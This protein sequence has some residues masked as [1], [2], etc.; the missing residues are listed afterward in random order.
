MLPSP[1]SSKPHP[2]LLRKSFADITRGWS[3]IKWGKTPVFVKHLT[4]FD[5]IE[6][7]DYYDAQLA[8]ARKNGI[9]SEV[10]KAKWL[11]KKGMW[12]KK[13]DLDLVMQRDF[14]KNL[15]L[16]KTKAFL[17]SQIAA[18]EK[19]LVVERKALRDM[20]EKRSASFG[21]ID[22][23]YAA[24]KMQFYYVGLSFYRDRGLTN[25]M[26]S[27][28]DV[29]QMDEDESYDL[30]SL[31]ID[32]ITRFDLDIIKRIS[33]ASFFVNSLYLCGEDPSRFFGKPVVDLTFYQTNLLSYGLY[34]KNVMS[35]EKVPEAIRDDPDKIEEFMNRTKASK[36]ALRTNLEG[37]STGIVGATSEDFEVLGLPEDKTGRHMVKP[38]M[39]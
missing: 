19:A 28:H 5:Q 17:K 8:K 23:K 6:V 27:Q 10:E 31:Y 25:R 20:E 38:S 24:Q 2:N 32:F 11:E 34:F 36:E 29:D 12:T 26:F 4:Q 14:V 7:D 1:P 37:G 9:P 35:G 39:I 3:E 18:Q 15:E 22:D 21:L 33:V 30:L 13:D 16:T